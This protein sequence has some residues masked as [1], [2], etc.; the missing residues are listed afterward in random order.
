MNFFPAVVHI[1]ILDVSY[2]ELL[3][4][5]KQGTHVHFVS[6]VQK[7]LVHVHGVQHRMISVDNFFVL[8][9]LLFFALF[10]LYVKAMYGLP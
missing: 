8:L 10:L 5:S 6:Y 7:T 3:Q 2:V 4:K 9:R 1:Y